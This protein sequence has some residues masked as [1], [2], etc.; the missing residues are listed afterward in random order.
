M[1][2]LYGVVGEGMGHATRSRVV[3]RHLRARGHAVLVASSGRARA[4]LAKEF[5]TVPLD[6]FELRYADG[7]LDA[8]ASALHN[9]RRAPAMLARAG[10]AFAAADRF[11]PG[12]VV[13]D[14]ESF[15]HL[16]AKARGLPV[17]SVD[18]IQ[19][20]DRCVHPPAV[21]A[22][23]EPAF[24]LA[25]AV[26]RAKLPGCDGYVVTTFFYPEVRAACRADTALVPPILRDEVLRA[27][28]RGDGP[29]LVYQTAVEDSR[30]LGALRALA[31]QRFVVYGLGRDAAEGNCTLKGFRDQE[32]V[33]DLAGARAVVANG[34]MS[35]LGEAVALGKPVYSVPIRD[36]AEQAMNA[37][38]LAGLGYGATSERFEPAALAAFLARVPAYA[39]ALRSVPR[40]DGNAALFAAVDR[41]LADRGRVN[42]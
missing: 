21:T 24:E 34:G 19:M 32:F 20:L 10:Q 33:D 36:H 41:F 6:G 18:N 2:V 28:P 31:P 16:Y 25:R 11:A 35:L 17:L 9:A 12:A 3:L 39:A 1:N 15:A 5:A 26:A 22:G 40:H 7:A 13:S 29:V 42:R 30:L 4:F 8:A 23:I 14:F 27:S 37:R 38:Y